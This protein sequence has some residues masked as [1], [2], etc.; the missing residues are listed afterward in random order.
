MAGSAAEPVFAEIVLRFDAGV[1]R[2]G[3]RTAIAIS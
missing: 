1:N 2:T 3:W